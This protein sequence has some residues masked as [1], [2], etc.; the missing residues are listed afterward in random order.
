MRLNCSMP[1]WSLVPMRSLGKHYLVA[2]PRQARYPGTVV[3]LPCATL[4]KWVHVCSI[5][6]LL[7]RRIRAVYLAPRLPIGRNSPWQ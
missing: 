6:R 1:L 2:F 3:R 5:I 4:D 7:D